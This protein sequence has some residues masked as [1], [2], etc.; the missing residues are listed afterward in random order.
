MDPIFCKH[1]RTKKIYVDA[2]PEEAFATKEGMDVSPCH[3]WCNLTQSVAGPDDRQVHKEA[4][5]AGRSC[6]RE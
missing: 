6:F 4:C 2:T 1:L 5:R 3:V